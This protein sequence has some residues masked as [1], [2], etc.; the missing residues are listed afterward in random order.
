MIRCS[1]ASI[2]RDVATKWC[3]VAEKRRNVT[4]NDCNVAG[5]SSRTREFG[6]SVADRV[7][8]ATESVDDSPFAEPQSFGD[9]I[10]VIQQQGVI[11]QIR[12]EARV[13][14]HRPPP[15][16]RENLETESRLACTGA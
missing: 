4:R 8:V 5:H 13:S 14:R 7:V 9:L 2:P 15:P 11:L 6:K 1:V 12:A 16:V 10:Q 3:S